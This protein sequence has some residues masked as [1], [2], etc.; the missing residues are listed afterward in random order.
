MSKAGDNIITEETI[1]LKDGRL[2]ILIRYSH[3]IDS[4]QYPGCLESIDD[5]AEFEVREEIREK[6]KES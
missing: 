1:R 6:E 4:V 3:I 2:L 5:G